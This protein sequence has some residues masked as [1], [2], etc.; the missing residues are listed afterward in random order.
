MVY[1]KNI[2]ERE[3]NMEHECVIGILNDYGYSPL[4]TISELLKLQPKS[5]YTMKQYCD[6]RYSTNLTRFVHCPYC[7]KKI[8]W[9]TIRKDL[10]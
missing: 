7:G 1:V 8:D 2:L 4:V 6:W 5:V 10:K 9:E 3:N